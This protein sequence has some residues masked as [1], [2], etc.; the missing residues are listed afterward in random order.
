M[1]IVIDLAAQ[2]LCLLDEQQQVIKQYQASTA[3]AGIGEQQGSMQTPRG[4][5]VVRA[6]IG[7]GL[8]IGAVL[9]GR[10]P[11]GEVH[12]PELA[13]QYPER[14]WIL[15]RILWLSGCQPGFNRLGQVDSMRRYIYIH[16]TP[17]DQPMGI[18][19]SHGCVRMRNADVVEL[20]E[21]VKPDCQVLMLDGEPEPRQQYVANVPQNALAGLQQHLHPMTIAMPISP[22]PA[23]SADAWALWSAEGRL[24]A[25]ATLTGSMGLM[26]WRAEAEGAVPDWKQ[27]LAAIIEGAR[28]WQWF[29]LRI[30]TVPA[31]VANAQSLDFEIVR[32][33]PEGILLRYWLGQPQT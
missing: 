24:L 23:L 15:S 16:G 4:L 10:R 2:T 30:L 31:F 29:E 25:L 20:F 17:D 28:S 11:T 32:C 13:E 27:L 18:P 22:V 7:A 19:A 26:L 14:D 33:L 9:R 1:K 8:P 12:T 5:H 3:A 21:L 6:K